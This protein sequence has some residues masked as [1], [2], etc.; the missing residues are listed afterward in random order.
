MAQTGLLDVAGPGI[1][2]VLEKS[3]EFWNGSVTN[4][5]PEEASF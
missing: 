4:H 2:A 5:G 3:R 1:S